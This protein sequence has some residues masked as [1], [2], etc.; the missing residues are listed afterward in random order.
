M[1]ALVMDVAFA[2]YQVRIIIDPFS[3]PWFKVP[4]DFLSDEEEK[5]SP[6]SKRRK[7]RHN[8]RPTANSSSAGEDEDEEGS[9]GSSSE[10][11]SDESGSSDDNGEWQEV[12]VGTPMPKD[13]EEARHVARARPRLYLVS[14]KGGRGDER[15]KKEW[16]G[17]ERG[18]DGGG[19]R[20]RKNEE[21]GYEEVERGEERERKNTR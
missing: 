1:W 14:G 11:D 20:Q 7:V 13:D 2:E 8:G 17:M 12:E 15:R 4:D 9:D 18:W 10:G 6:P 16:R 21:V 3:P 5:A 19:E